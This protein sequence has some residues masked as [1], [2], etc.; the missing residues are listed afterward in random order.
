MGLVGLAHVLWKRRIA[1]AIGALLA[2]V[3]AAVGIQRG[4]G[5]VST[6]SSSSKVLI[7]T[8]K[9]LVADARARGA[10][11][12]YTRARLVG[13]LIADDDAK[14]AVA[15]KAG[16][17]PSELAIAG[18]GAAAPPDAIAPLAEQ[19]IAVAKPIAP[20]LISV[21]VA[22]SLPIVSISATAPDR[23]QAVRL[24]RAAVETL[25]SVASEAPGGGSSVAIRRLGR[26]LIATK[27]AGGGMAK[28]VAGALALFAL[29][30][31]GCVLFD[32]VARRRKLRGAEW[33]DARGAVG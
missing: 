32:G 14:A 6:V 20:Y 1:V 28:P 8:P 13:N 23:D 29:W 24:D 21:E 16:L 22:P 11:T 2:I 30:C 10:G 18:P 31:L 19:A 4:A 3:V 7:D 26:P 15:R 12:I 27:A 5:S 25:S 17:Q 33:P 9:S